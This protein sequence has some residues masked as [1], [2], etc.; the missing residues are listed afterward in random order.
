MTDS[1]TIRRR[2]HNHM[3]LKDRML[4][5]LLVPDENCD[6]IDTFDLVAADV[7]R[8]GCCETPADCWRSI[9]YLLA[10]EAARQR[11]ATTG[12]DNAAAQLEHAIT[13]SL[14]VMAKL[15]AET[16]QP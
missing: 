9:A 14:T 16:G 3:S 8:G 13:M 1:S 12:L 15:D 10:C 5:A 7:N 11:V 6:D 4:L 2:S